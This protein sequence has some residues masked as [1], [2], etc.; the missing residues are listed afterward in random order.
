[1]LSGIQIFF[2]LLFPVCVCYIAL[3][4]SIDRFMVVWIIFYLYVKINWNADA[5]PDEK[6][7]DFCL[8]ENFLYYLHLL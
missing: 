6:R 8:P 3:M 5:V 4:E 1:M 7:R 2:L